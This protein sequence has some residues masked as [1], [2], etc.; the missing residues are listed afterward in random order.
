[1]RSPK[2]AAAVALGLG[3]VGLVAW[4]KRELAGPH[5]PAPAAANDAPTA[6]RC[7]FR[8]NDTAAFAF[9]STAT[10]DGHAGEDRFEGVL[11]WV[12]AHEAKGDEP[13][14]LRAALGSVALRQALS[15]EK[16]SATELMDGPFYVRVDSTCRFRG[17]GFSPRWSASSRHRVESLFQGSELV[18]PND[19]SSSQWDAE[20]QDGVGSYVAKYQASTL[21]SAQSIVR[22]KSHYRADAGAMQMGIRIQLLGAR[23]EARF[24]PSRPGWFHEVSG[25]EHVRVHFQGQAPQGF[26][27][28]FH[29]KRDDARYVAP[30]DTLTLA[31]AD[32]TGATVADA[33]A[34]NAAPDPA[35]AGVAHDAA[36]ARFNAF[37]Q[38]SGKSGI[39]PAARYLADWLRA[40]PEESGRLLADL[41]SGAVDKAAHSALFLAL[42]LAGTTASRGVLADALVDAQLSEVNRARAAA[43][44]ADH[45]E[46]TGA[47]AKALLDAAHAPGSPMVASA[48][49]LG[50][51][52]LAGRT[53]EGDP[54]RAELRSTLDAELARAKTDDAAIVVVDALG[55]SGDAAFAPALDTRLR[56]G[57]PALRAHAAEAL[58]HLPADVARPR[59]LAQLKTEASTG[60]STAI[61]RSL[62]QLKG[63][64][65]QAEIALA[66]QKLATSTSADERAAVIDWLG[67]AHDQA[68]AR[69]VLAAHFAMEPS[70][71]LKQRIG[72]FVTPAELHAAAG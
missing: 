67:S 30:S 13:A 37:L 56:T 3:V 39:Y 59:L 36:L 29:L 50:L 5:A 46:P 11:S 4:S 41:K 23:A 58:G 62:A 7:A 40:H 27:L 12:V 32:F 60:V 51:G 64:L 44:L 48:S 8:A 33:H 57:R 9:A 53:H 31:L 49:L 34:S 66:A 45:G 14:V 21:G 25:R 24:D 26:V 42:E 43:A 69:Q 55:N 70:V 47:A 72:T 61:V 16:A 17:L 63:D 52:R 10:L 2:I 71:A 65:G 20:Q 54:L 19:A 35:L 68:G 1:M 6:L 22:T 28:A 18:L 38:K 15:E